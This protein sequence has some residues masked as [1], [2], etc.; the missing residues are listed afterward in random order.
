MNLLSVFVTVTLVNAITLNGKISN[1]PEIELAND[2]VINGDNLGSRITVVLTQKG[3]KS[4]PKK[5]LVNQNYEFSFYDVENGSYD[6]NINSHDFLIHPE[7]FNIEVNDTTIISTD[8]YIVPNILST[9]R[10]ITETGL[11][12]SVVGKKEYY[13]SR[14]QSLKQMVMSSPFG[15]IFR[16]TPLTILFV[17]VML[18]SIGPYIIKY[19]NPELYKKLNELHEQ[20]EAKQNEQPNKQPKIE[21]ISRTEQLSD[22]RRRKN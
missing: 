17:F 16:S 7:R 18:A 1:I 8:Y 21:E 10:D 20:E 3:A 5:A 14:N 13:E 19:G 22:V 9:T 11:L 15:Y 2:H 12:V 4:V 6:L